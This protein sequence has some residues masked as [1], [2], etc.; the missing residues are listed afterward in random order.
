MSSSLLSKGSTCAGEFD[1]SAHSDIVSYNL[2]FCLR[3]DCPKSGYLMYSEPACTYNV[4][5]D[6][7]D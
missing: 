1:K 4:V 6:L 7:T 2:T 5:L 3:R